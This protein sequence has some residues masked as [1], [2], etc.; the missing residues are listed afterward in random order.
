MG[1]SSYGQPRY[2]NEFKRYLELRSDGLYKLNTNYIDFAIG[3][4]AHIFPE[5]LIKELGAPRDPAMEIE[6]KHSDIAKSL[7]LRLDSLSHV[8]GNAGH[9]GDVVH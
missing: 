6:Q 7:Q 2:I 8:A 5:K 9:G 3:A 1:L 4:F